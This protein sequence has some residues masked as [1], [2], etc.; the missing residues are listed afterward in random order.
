[1]LV[2][3]A[4]G[5][6]N[7]NGVLVGGNILINDYN[8]QN[9]LSIG[10]INGTNALAYSNVLGTGTSAGGAIFVAQYI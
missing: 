7:L 8:G 6:C 9:G 4:G 3:G 10:G 5:A 1:V 2:G